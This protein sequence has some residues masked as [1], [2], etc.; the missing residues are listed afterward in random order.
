MRKRVWGWGPSSGWKLISTKKLGKETPTDGTNSFLSS[1]PLLNWNLEKA[2]LSWIPLRKKQGVK[3]NMMPSGVQGKLWLW[4]YLETFYW[5][6]A[7]R[8]YGFRGWIIKEDRCIT[9][10]EMKG[11]MVWP[12]RI[13]FSLFSIFFPGKLIKAKEYAWCFSAK[14]NEMTAH[15]WWS[16]RVFISSRHNRISGLFICFNIVLCLTECYLLL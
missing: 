4:R 13:P 15:V 1:G 9:K 6:H 8:C 3:G 5:S 2:E 11:S 10:S 12:H 16:H 14:Q 7:Q